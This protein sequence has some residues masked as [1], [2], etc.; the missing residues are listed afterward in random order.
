M[1]EHESTVISQFAQN[2]AEVVAACRFFNNEAVSLEAL[3]KATRAE[4][5]SNVAGRHV[6]AIQDTTEVNYAS[7]SGLLKASDPE[8]GPVGNNRDVGFFLH[9]TLALDAGTG[10]ALGFADLYLWNRRWDKGDKHS[11][12]YKYQPIEQ[13]ESYRW[14]EASHQSKRTLAAARKVTLLADRE[15]DIYEIY[16]EFLLVPDERTDVLLRSRSDRRLADRDETLYAY[17]NG[18]SVAGCYPLEVR[19]NNGRRARRTLLEVRFGPVRLAKPVSNHHDEA[20]AE[21]VALYAVEARERAER[22]PEGEEPILWRLLTTHPV[23]RFEEALEVI[24][25]YSRRPQIEQVFRLIQS[26]GLRLEQSQLTRGAALK[27][28][29]V[30]SLQVALVLMQLVS[31]RGGE[32]DESATLIFTEESL[33]FLRALQRKLEG[34][35]P[36]QQCAHESGTLAWASW[37]VGR[38]GGWTGYARAS[39]PGPI[40]MRRGLQR[41]ESQYAGWQLAQQV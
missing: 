22:V 9:P 8:L 21:S 41:L 32:V 28:L 35:T 19:P 25:Y 14:I 39:P 27:K 31:A 5:A 40:T 33:P 7:H 10:F 34:K 36:K 30:L 16:E 20:L 38:L 26:E 17:L 37:V 4:T 1:T 6:L 12:G 13:K 18:L 29:S 11:R 23:T 2:R 3:V 15:A 24:G